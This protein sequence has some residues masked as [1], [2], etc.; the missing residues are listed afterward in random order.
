MHDTVDLSA[1]TAGYATR[2]TPLGSGDLWNTDGLEL[3]HYIRNVARGIMRTGKSKSRSIAMAVAA[4]KRWKRGGDDVSPEVQ[5]AATK[6]VAQLNAA[7]AKAKATP[8]KSDHANTTGAVELSGEQPRVPTGNPGAGQFMGT[9]DPTRVRTREVPKV[10][11]HNAASLREQLDQATNGGTTELS[12]QTAREILLA[13]MKVGD[14]YQH[15]PGT[16]YHWRHGWKPLDVATALLWGKTKAAEKLHK[17]G[18][19]HFNAEPN[20]WWQKNPHLKQTLN[21]GEIGH[22]MHQPTLYKAVPDAAA[23]AKITKQTHFV[24]NDKKLG[25]YITAQRPKGAHVTVEPGGFAGAVGKVPADLPKALKESVA[26][27]HERA[28]DK[29]G[30]ATPTAAQLRQLVDGTPATTATTPD[31]PTISTVFDGLPPAPGSKSDGYLSIIKANSV[32]KSLA[33]RNNTSHYVAEGQVDGQ[34]KYLVTTQP[35]KGAVSVHDPKPTPSTTTPSA[36]T[37]PSTPAAPSPAPVTTGPVD[38]FTPV[39]T[40]TWTKLSGPKGSNPG[41]VYR[42]TNGVDHY[43]KKPKTADHARNEVLA[44]ELYRLAGVDIADVRLATVDGQMGTASRMLPEAQSNL[45]AKLD[46]PDYKARVQEGFA[47]D[48]WL[49]NWD[50]AGLGYDNIVT[51]DG[52]PVRIDAGGALLYRAQGAPKGDQFGPTVPEWASLRDGKKNPQATKVF[53]GMSPE[54]M[55]ASAQRVADITPAQIDAAVDKAGFDPDTSAKL[56]NLLKA[57]RADIA[58][59]AEINLPENSGS[60]AYAPTPAD[61]PKPTPTVN[62]TSYTPNTPTATSG[63]VPE[64]T[65]GQIKVHTIVAQSSGKPTYMVWDGMGFLSKSEPSADQVSWKVTPDGKATKVDPAESAPAPMVSA[66]TGEAIP[67]N[68]FAALVARAAAQNTQGAATTPDVPPTPTASPT[69]NPG[70]PEAEE[71]PAAILDGA[72]AIAQSLG[73]PQYVKLDGTGNFAFGDHPPAGPVKTKPTHW[74]VNPDGSISKVEAG[75]HTPITSSTLPPD[76]PKPKGGIHP[77]HAATQIATESAKITGQPYYT[78][79]LD[80]GDHGVFDKAPTGA[81]VQHNPDGTTTAVGGS[82]AGSDVGLPTTEVKLPGYLSPIPMPGKS[83]DSKAKIAAA[84]ADLKAA[85]TIQG[86]ADPKHGTL[87]IAASMQYAAVTGK[88]TF[89]STTKGGMVTKRP[90]KAVSYYEFRPDGT[91]WRHHGGSILLDEMSPVHVLNHIGKHLGK[92]YD[93]I[94]ATKPVK[95]GLMEPVTVKSIDPTKWQEALAEVKQLANAT[96]Q[97]HHLAL[98]GT[99]KQG[100]STVVK[101]FYPDGKEPAVTKLGLTLFKESVTGDPTVASTVAKVATAPDLSGSGSFAEGIQKA[102]KTGV[103]H[104]QTHQSAPITTQRPPNNSGYDAFMPDGTMWTHKAGDVAIEEQKPDKVAKLVATDIDSFTKEQAFNHPSAGPAQGETATVLDP[105]TLPEVGYTKKG[106][107]PFF[108]A[109]VGTY[110]EGQKVVGKN[111]AGNPTEYEVTGIGK[112]FKKKGVEQQYAYITE[113]GNPVHIGAQPSREAP[114]TT[115]GPITLPKVRS[116]LSFK[117]LVADFKR[118]V[119]PTPREAAA[120]KQYGSENYGELHYQVVNKLLRTGG[121]LSDKQK[122]FVAELHSVAR[123]YEAPETFTVR[124]GISGKFFPKGNLTGKVYQDQGFASASVP[125]HGGFGGDVK[126]NITVPKGFHGIAL[127]GVAMPD[128]GSA[129]SYPENEFLLPAGTKYMILKDEMKNGVRQIDAILVPAGTREIGQQQVTKHDAQRI[130]EDPSDAGLQAGAFTPQ[131]LA[132]LQRH[133]TT[134]WRRKYASK[135]NAPVPAG[136]GT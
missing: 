15:V 93:D 58:K 72:K 133:G 62:T 71:P 97:P 96:G 69:P 94:T 34:T 44:T 77:P 5:A 102:V 134:A 20:S 3:P 6:A 63:D 88:P 123:K 7:R 26:K 91:L 12:A 11:E 28:N 40:S 111:S 10:T 70:A 92:S 106:K 24:L 127:A 110:S 130:W 25:V 17:I 21:V 41:G 73:K 103:P 126:F 67:P 30:V 45:K 2:S 60:K 75:V 36:P 83:P 55:R 46:D 18:A 61:A 39:D 53:S 120:V 128:G 131:G 129:A 16:A 68:P 136:V 74:K 81:Y 121:E 122:K 59:N 86:D 132:Y 98:D 54:A 108:M 49:A 104:Y 90:G 14:S 79:R 78:Q 23:L 52:K 37:T 19:G 87:N 8:N 42:D 22:G 105:E 57:R 82:G 33:N 31:T 119:R 29:V 101:N 76:A 115:P 4:V 113:T 65:P 27:A 48:A 112:P 32:A 38:R 100:E 99:I 117:S 107:K 1:K 109:A 85:P 56:K 50:V 80:N 125:P 124:R 118:K 95:A 64:P 66:V 47:V 114:G 89:W 9:D 35:P 84:I 43:V 13:S 135:Q 51:A 116:K